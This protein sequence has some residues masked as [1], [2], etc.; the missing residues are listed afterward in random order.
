MALFGQS[1]DH[2]LRG[3]HVI[4]NDEQFHFQL[5]FDQR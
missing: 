5:R 1:F 3:G 2:I 4:F